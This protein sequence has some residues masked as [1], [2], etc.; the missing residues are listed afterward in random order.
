LV[1]KK[2]ATF[3]LIL[4]TKRK[5]SHRSRRDWRKKDQEEECASDSWRRRAFW[6]QNKIGAS[7]I[8]QISVSFS[9]D[10]NPIL[11]SSSHIFLEEEM[12]TGS[13]WES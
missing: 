5:W 7:K 8:S 13:N 4:T 10:W 3:H 2:V 1:E 12:G 11:P 6:R 9:S